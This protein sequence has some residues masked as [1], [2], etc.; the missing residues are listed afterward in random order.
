MWKGAKLESNL[1]KVSQNR[2]EAGLCLYCGESLI[3]GVP[4]DMGMHIE[5]K[6]KVEA[7]AWNQIKDRKIREGKVK[8]L[9]IK[10][11]P[12]LINKNHSG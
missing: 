8:Q 4:A 10:A 12:H 1:V 3:E 11:K 6:K 5:C 2:I 9:K 7:I